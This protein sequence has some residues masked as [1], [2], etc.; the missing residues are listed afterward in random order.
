MKLDID[1]FPPVDRYGLWSITHIGKNQGIDARRKVNGIP[2]VVVGAAALAALTGP[3]DYA[4]K[5]FPPAAR[6]G[7]GNAM[8]R[9]GESD[10][11]NQQKQ[12][13]EKET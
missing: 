10:T 9:L 3:D 6:D 11:G 1:H 8:L 13:S 4:G 2:A 5:S 12:D 7:T